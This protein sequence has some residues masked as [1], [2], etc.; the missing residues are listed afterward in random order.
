MTIS[1]TSKTKP[2]KVTVTVAFQGSPI[3]CSYKATS[4]KGSA[5]NTGN[6]I[7]FSKQKFTKTSGICPASANF[8]ATFGPVTDSS[9]TG[10]PK[11]FVN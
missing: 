6:T 7:T 1:G 5:S 3:T 10:S 11:V 4:V 8:S 2:I 9:V